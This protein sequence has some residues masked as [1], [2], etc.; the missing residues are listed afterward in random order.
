MQTST[1][2]HYCK[3]LRCAYT[4]QN[5]NN[6]NSQTPALVLIHP[7]GV[8]LSGTFWQRFIEAWLASHDDYTIYNPD[9][10]GCGASDLPAV[11]YYS[12]DWANQLKYLIENEVKK[13]VILIVQGAS[14]PIAIELLQIIS[15]P[16]LIKGLVLST[17]P[18]WRTMTEKAK[19]LQNKLLWNLLFNSPIGLGKLFYNYAR[20]RQFIESF[21]ERQLFGD[22]DKVDANWLDSLTTEAKNIRTRYAVFSFLAGFWRKDYTKD[23]SEIKQPTLVV[24]GKQTSSISKE[25]KGETV[26]KRSNLYLKHLSNGEVKIIEGR[27]VLPY[28]STSEFVRVVSDFLKQSI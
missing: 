7:I 22:A 11:A 26:E 24:W 10:L 4:V 20:R 5:K 23:I 27:N 21:S 19:P 2:F 28:E 1:Q 6:S 18:A 9:L 3:D 16:D 13:P 8:G 14:F 17:P 12:I 15:N 25:S